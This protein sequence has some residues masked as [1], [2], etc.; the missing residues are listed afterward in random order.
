MAPTCC[1]NK[2]QISEP[3]LGH[4]AG[5]GASQPWRPPARSAAVRDPAALS[6]ALMDW[7]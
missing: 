3:S 6:S 4:M 2:A 5:S 1:F 7:Q